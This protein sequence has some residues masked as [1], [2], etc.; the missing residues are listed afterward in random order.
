M[1]DKIKIKVRPHCSTPATEPHWE[2]ERT[3]HS[4][5]PVGSCR[6]PARRTSGC[7][8]TSR[9]QGLSLAG[10]FFLVGALRAG[11]VNRAAST[12][13]RK[14]GQW[15]GGGGRR[16]W[17][18]WREGESVATPSPACTQSTS[19]ARWSIPGARGKRCN[20]RPRP[21]SSPDP[22]RCGRRNSRHG[23]GGVPPWG[24]RG[25]AVFAL[26]HDRWRSPVAAR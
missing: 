11:D 22:Q 24:G 5:V 8:A 7:P 14:K 18:R 16:S 3:A 17:A 6:T 10:L 15:S 12:G 1:L 4:G 20:R 25:T 21:P 26:R 19:G 2:P 23:R 13:R 9:L